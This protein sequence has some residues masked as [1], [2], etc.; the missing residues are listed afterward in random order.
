MDKLMRLIEGVL[1]ALIGTSVMIVIMQIV[2]RYVFRSPLGWTEQI[3]RAEFIWIVMLGIP[4]MFNR[5]ITMSFDV[6]LQKLKGKTHKSVQ[7]ALRLIGMT[8]CGFYF[9]ASVEL[10]RTASN[11]TAAG[12]KMPVNALYGAQPVCA[13]LLFLVFLRQ[14]INLIRDFKKEEEDK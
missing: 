7:I 8:F 13:A 11:L 9:T 5:G 6:L 4:V 14:I 10:C 2:W 3:A 1:I 12:V